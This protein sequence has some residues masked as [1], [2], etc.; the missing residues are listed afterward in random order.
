MNTSFVFLANG[1]EEVE[2]LT[3]IDIMRR[4]GMDVVTVS[5]NDTLEAEGAH[6]VTVKADALIS[7]VNLNNAEWLICP[8]G[9][10]GASN[11]VACKPL[12][13]ALIAQNSKGGK[14]AAIC[15]SPSVIFGPLGLLEGK[16]AV[17]YPGMERGMTGA[18]V[19]Y[20]P[21]AID[22]NIITGNGP[23]AAS[24]FS[25]A[26]VQE[27]KGEEVARQVAEGM[28]FYDKL[29]EEFYF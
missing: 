16:H 14:I 12:T 18:I 23:A 4:A 28:L 1:F 15:A 22:G 11:L 7:E 5:I 24:A 19:G 20:T 9:M 10:P 13:N 29:K 21:I 2:A 25:F 17:C 27:S 26:I 8:G 6:G 3:T